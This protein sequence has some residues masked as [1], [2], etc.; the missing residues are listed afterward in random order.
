MA[1]SFIKGGT[2][3]GSTSL[4][5]T[6]SNGLVITGY[7]ESEQITMC[8]EVNPTFVVPFIVYE[9]S[10]YYDKNRPT[11]EQ[12][13]KFAIDVSPGPP[14]SISGFKA[15]PGFAEASIPARVG[16]DDDEDED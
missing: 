9:C 11:W 14:K 6:C 10:N 5:R 15:G 16:P 1:K 3:I 12:M 4:C 8:Y 2:P 7:R 13:K